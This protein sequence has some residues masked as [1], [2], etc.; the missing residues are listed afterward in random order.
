M[1]LSSMV[2]TLELRE[3]LG[4]M[5]PHLNERTRRMVAASE[6]AQIGYGGAT[7]ISVTRL[8]LPV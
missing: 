1:L 8:S 2:S 5:W 6:A 7:L 3:K 4:R